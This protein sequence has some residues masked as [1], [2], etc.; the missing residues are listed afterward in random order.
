MKSNKENTVDDSDSSTD[1]ANVKITN[2]D[3]R[4]NSDNQQDKSNIPAEV[5]T[6]EYY[7]TSVQFRNSNSNN[8]KCANPTPGEK[9]YIK[10]IIQVLQQGHMN[11]KE[12]KVLKIVLSGFSGREC[13]VT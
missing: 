12:K 8:M 13:S 5:N 7:T 4:I 3:N 6:S 9:L 1:G 11:R 2:D 10:F